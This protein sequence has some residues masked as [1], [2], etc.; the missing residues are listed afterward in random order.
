MTAKATGTSPNPPVRADGPAPPPPYPRRWLAVAVLLAAFMVDLVSVTIVNVALP[1]MGRAL[2][3]GPAELE[4]I[5]AGYLLAFAVSLITAARLGD[6]IGR[7]RVFLASVALFALASL[8][9]AVAPGTGTLIGARIV[10]GIAAAGIAPQVLSTVYTIFDARERAAVFGVL[11]IVSGLSQALGLLLGGVLVSAD[12]AG[13]GWRS[14][15]VVLVPVAVAIAALGAAWVP[16]T[17]APGAARPKP[18]AALV[19][20]VG[21]VAIIAPLLEG[22]RLGWPWWTWPCMAGGVAAVVLLALAE[23]GRGR[24]ERTG[25][26]AAPSSSALLPLDLLRVR[27][28]GAA[29]VI[30]LVAFG[31]FSGLLLVLAL[32]MQD[33]LGFS[34]LLA[35][36]V[37]VAIPIGSLPI[38]PFMGRLTLRLGRLTVGLGCLVIAAGVAA[39]I[40][41]A[42][43]TPDVSAWAILPGLALIGAGVNLTMPAL[44]TLYMA[45]VPAHHA[46]SASGIITTGQQFAGGLGVA[47]LAA[48]FFG[49]LGG[50][51]YRSAI[52]ASATVAAVV[53]A[54]CAPLCLAMSKPKLGAPAGSAA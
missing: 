44:T 54:L 15:F 7:K 46:A 9:C 5:S 32:W 33:G 18:L 11:G 16:E 8:A 29:L 14:I 51:D 42:L 45:E 49:Q 50:G 20:T 28:V 10:Q 41:A 13:L 37:T 38:A 3:A 12:L 34:P 43:G 4:W 23:H 19:L 1:T 48:T 25:E 2:D 27:T 53:V 17:R 22:T 31:A 39:L 40:P 47:L 35:G 30:Q 26:S 36:L 21:L 52:T 24:P 6:Q